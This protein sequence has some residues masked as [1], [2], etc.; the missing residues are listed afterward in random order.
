MNCYFLADESIMIM[1]YFVHKIV[2]N[3]LPVSPSNCRV[4]FLLSLIEIRFHS[5]IAQVGLEL[6]K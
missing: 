6:S 3:I 4:Y 2:K 5:M 1:S